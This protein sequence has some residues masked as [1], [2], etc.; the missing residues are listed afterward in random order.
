[1]YQINSAEEHDAVY[2]A[3]YKQWIN[4]APLWLGLK[5]FHL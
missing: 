5:Q 3:L 2:E 4:N 1:M